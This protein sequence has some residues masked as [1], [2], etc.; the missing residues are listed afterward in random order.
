MAADRAQHVAEVVRP[1]LDAGAVVVTDRYLYSSVA[2]QGHGRDLGPDAVA[3][4]SA[5]ATAGLEADLVLLLTVPPE[6]RDARL[7]ERGGHDRFEQAGAAFHERV[8]AGFRAQAAA[9]PPGGSCST[10]TAPSSTSP[11]RSGRPWHRACRAVAGCPSWR[12]RPP[13][14]SGPRPSA[15][16]AW[17]SSCGRLPASRSTPTCS[18]GPRGGAPVPSPGPSPPRCSPPGCPPTRSTASASSS[19]RTTSPTC[20]T[21]EAEGNQLRKDEVDEL[22]RL[23]FR[24]PTERP[25]KVLVVPHIDTAGPGGVVADAQGARGAVG[26]HGVG[27]AG[28]RAAAG[29][30]HDRLPL[31]RRSGS[32][33][34]R[35]TRSPRRARGRGRRPR[36]GAHGRPG[37]RW[38]RRAGPPAGRRRAPRPCG[39]RRGA[40]SPTSSTAP[41][42][43]P[44][45][46]PPRCGRP[47]TTPS[48]P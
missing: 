8:E 2:Y 47:S 39:W 37:R 30:G 33:P 25:Y 32:T 35:R 27:A 48:A 3:A 36:R 17:P 40:G 12:L 5:F 1:A 11:S 26:H 42:T 13:S 45:A 14:T 16:S 44:G 29:D 38:R 41:A 4:L 31:G 20:L 6:V 46:S 19:P 7:A 22:I 23:A 34:C 9:D 10:A 43:P 15:R 28:R 18:S 24:A 21:V